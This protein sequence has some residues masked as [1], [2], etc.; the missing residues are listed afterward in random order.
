MHFTS[1]LQKLNLL[2]GTASST[3][4]IATTM[5]T[6]MSDNKESAAISTETTASKGNKQMVEQYLSNQG[7]AVCI[8]RLFYVL[9]EGVGDVDPKA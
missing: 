2:P 8:S 6:T 1:V 3:T 5:T 7:K 4:M 9:S